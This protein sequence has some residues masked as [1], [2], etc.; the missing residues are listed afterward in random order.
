MVTSVSSPCRP[1]SLILGLRCPTRSLTF[2]PG[3]HPSASGPG[4]GSQL[5]CT[6]QQG[7]TR[8]HIAC[9]QSL[10]VGLWLVA[11]GPSS[12]VQMPVISRTHHFEDW[13]TTNHWTSGHINHTA[14]PPYG[15][16]P[17]LRCCACPAAQ[18]PRAPKERGSA[19][20][21][22]PLPALCPHLMPV[23]TRWLIL[24][25]HQTVIMGE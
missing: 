15:P 3:H 21:P 17:S 14:P 23:L 24:A 10:P 4:P 25:S 6:A 22:Q 11:Q 9:V 12:P 7:R 13:E 2:L 8:V 1:H 5:L 19:P 18:C 16:F 20:C